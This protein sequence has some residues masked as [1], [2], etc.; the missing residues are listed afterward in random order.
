LIAIQGIA[1]ATLVGMDGSPGWR[2]VRVLIVA[3]VIV[4]SIRVARRGGGAGVSLTELVLGIAGTVAGAGIGVL[5]LVKVGAS[6]ETVTGLTALATGGVL[7]VRGAAALT[8]RLPGWWRLLALPA[9]LALL[10]F[11]LYPMTLAVNVTNRPATSLGPA[12]PSDLGLSY[13][14]VTVRTSDGLRLSG[15]FVPSRNES[16]VLLL[17]GAGSTRS[18]VLD[19]GGVLARRG[20]GVLMLDTRGHGRSEGQAMDLGWSGDLDIAAA[21][22]FLRRRP[23]VDPDRVA[24]VGLS[25]GGEQAIAALGSDPRIRAVVAEGVTGMQAADHGWLPGGINGV[26][27]RGLEW[28]LYTAADLMTDASKPTPMRDAIAEA[29]PTPILIIAGG[30]ERDEANAGRWFREA[31]PTSVDLWVVPGAGHTQG[32]ATQPARWEARVTRFLDAVLR[33]AG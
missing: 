24:L 2:A 25:M 27:Q 23:D 14:E 9:A 26:A 10:V 13:E 17:H 3:S 33:G 28:M 20:Y 30:A 32:L 6:L 8:R 21:I 19:H 1:I 15:W 18:S 29:A 4:A 31:S 12:L 22:S 5:Y 7:L 11:V 16:A